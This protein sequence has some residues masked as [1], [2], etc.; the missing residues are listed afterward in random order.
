MKSILEELYNGNIYPAELIFPKAPEYRPLNKRISD[1][2]EMWQKKLPEDD[3][4][5]LDNLLD[6]HSQSSSMEASESF[7]YGF[8]LGALIM[9]E[10]LTEKEKLVRGE[11]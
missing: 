8:R 5:Q 3:Y 11:D 4:N 6:L 7:L 1:T 9:I 10:V 2:L